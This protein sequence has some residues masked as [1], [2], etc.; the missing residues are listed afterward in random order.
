[1][2]PSLAETLSL[3]TGE[4]IMADKWSLVPDEFMRQTNR[5]EF[6][7]SRSEELIANKL[8]ARGLNY[9]YEQPLC[10]ITGRR[11]FPD[12]TIADRIRGVTYY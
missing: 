6:V 9:G 3:I 4:I 7:R 10:M 11:R 2:L 12:F 5:G 1:V 8:H